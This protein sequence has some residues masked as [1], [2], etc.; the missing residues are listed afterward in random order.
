MRRQT[1]KQKAA[2]KK[3]LVHFQK[4]QSGNPGG[5]PR[6]PDY[7]EGVKKLP[8]NVAAKLWSKWLSMKA[9]DLR[10]HEDDWALSA[11]ELGICRAILGDIKHGDLRNIEIGLTRICGKLGDAPPTDDSD[12][13]NGLSQDELLS[14]VQKAIRVMESVG[15]KEAEET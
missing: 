10:A 9:D 12:E 13:L 1:E 14:R 2:A 4:G 7:L 8:N 6:T 3:N 11:L 5:K 15:A